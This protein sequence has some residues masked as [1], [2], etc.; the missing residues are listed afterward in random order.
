MAVPKLSGELNVFIVDVLREQ[1]A[2]MDMSKK[3]LASAAGVS[4]TAIILMEAKKRSPS[5]ELVIRLSMSMGVSV[6]SIVAKAERRLAKTLSNATEAQSGPKTVLVIK[7][8][9]QTKHL[10]E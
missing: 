3:K 9:N 7:P 8:R 5:L 6:S 4:R 1:R 10:S 2:Q